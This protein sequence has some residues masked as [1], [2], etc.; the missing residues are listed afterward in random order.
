MC[1]EVGGDGQLHMAFPPKASLMLEAVVGWS[2]WLCLPEGYETGRGQNSC[3]LPPSEG[4][5]KPERHTRLSHL[6]CFSLTMSFNCLFLETELFANEICFQSGFSFFS[7]I[8]LK[9]VSSRRASHPITH[10][11]THTTSPP[12][13]PQTNACQPTFRPKRLEGKG[14]RQTPIRNYR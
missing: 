2:C 6:G 9:Q 4:L 1:C 5:E 12:C 7:G 13:V 10:T 3:H 11:F 14:S 8:Y